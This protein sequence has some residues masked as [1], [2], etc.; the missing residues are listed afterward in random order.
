MKVARLESM[1]ATPS[2]PNN[3]VSAA[4]HAEPSANSSRSGQPDA[5]RAQPPALEDASAGL[6]LPHSKTLYITGFTGGAPF[7]G[8]MRPCGSTM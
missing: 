6:L 5:A 7:S 2:L 1:P 4:K 3:A 8:C